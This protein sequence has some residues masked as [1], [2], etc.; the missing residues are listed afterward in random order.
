MQTR[1][2]AVSLP[3][4]EPVSPR[5]FSYALLQP[6]GLVVPRLFSHA[7]LLLQHIS[8]RLFSHVPLRPGEPVSPPFSSVPLQPGEPVPFLLQP[9]EPVLP[10]PF[11]LAL[12]QP[13]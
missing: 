2:D 6:S 11:S 3:R 8:P 5:L 9:G 10:R 1:R 12:F 4:G 13:V 7:P